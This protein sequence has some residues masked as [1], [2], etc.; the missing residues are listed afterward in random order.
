MMPTLNIPTP[1]RLYTKGTK[2]IDLRAADVRGAVQELV[3]EYPDLN[4]HLFTEDGV[5]RPY[6]NLFLNDE[7]IRYLQGLDTELNDQD[8]LRIIPSIAGGN[9]NCPHQIG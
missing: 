8:Q 4:S 9:H 6:V 7:D 3:S 5:L 2:S 1:L